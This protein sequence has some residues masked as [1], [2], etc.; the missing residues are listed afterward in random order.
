MGSRRRSGS[1]RRLA[2]V[3]VTAER[4]LKDAESYLTARAAGDASLRALDRAFIA[5][6]RGDAPDASIQELAESTPMRSYDVVALGVLAEL[7]GWSVDKQRLEEGIAWLIDVELKRGAVPAPVSIDGIALLLLGLAGSARPQLR[8]WHER[9]S[10]T[11]PDHIEPV[12]VR[13]SPEARLALARVGKGQANESDEGRLLDRLV[14]GELPGEPLRAAVLLLALSHVRRAQPVAL[15]RRA[16]IEHLVEMLKGVQRSLEHWTWEDNAKVKN[17][18]AR[19]WNVDHEYHVQN[20]LW[21]VLAPVFPD[22][23]KEEVGAAVG[24]VQPRV[25]LGFPSLRVV[26]EVKFVRST[27]PLKHMVNEIAE[28][29]SLYFVPGSKYERMIAFIWDDGARSEQHETLLKG[30]RLLERVADAVI[31]SRPGKMNVEAQVQP[32]ASGAVQPT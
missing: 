12:W 3:P 7:A 21:A 23:L 27:T 11:A 24:P 22:L 14:A 5:W 6:L 13:D 18:T 16:T 26:V 4:L 28:D 8:V 17:G 32:P 19:K 2:V 31:L 9:A 30:L 1:G 25:D 20:L 15:P 10:A 29:A